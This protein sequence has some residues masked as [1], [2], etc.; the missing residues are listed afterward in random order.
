MTKK[1]YD[2]M[3]QQRAAMVA[4]RNQKQVLETL[5][6]DDP[7]KIRMVKYI[8]RYRLPFFDEHGP[9]DLPWLA[10]MQSIML[11]I[12][13]KPVFL[14]F[15]EGEHFEAT[16]PRLNEMRRLA[17]RSRGLFAPLEAAFWSH[18]VILAMSRNLQKEMMAGS[19]DS[20][21]MWKATI[22]TGSAQLCSDI[23]SRDAA[24]VSLNTHANSDGADKRVLRKLIDVSGHFSTA[25]GDAEQAPGTDGVKCLDWRS[26]ADFIYPDEVYRMPQKT[27]TKETRIESLRLQRQLRDQ[28]NAVWPREGQPLLTDTHK[29]AEERFKV[30]QMLSTIVPREVQEHKER[31]V[32]QFAA[33]PAI[34]H[35]PV[36][37]YS[38]RQRRPPP[39]SI[40]S[41]SEADSQLDN[42]PAAAASPSSETA[43]IAVRQPKTLEDIEFLVKKMQPLQT[44]LAIDT[45]EHGSFSHRSPVGWKSGFRTAPMSQEEIAGARAVEKCCARQRQ[46]LR[47]EIII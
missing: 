35:A 45:D 33:L 2:R 4:A 13:G 3:A 29:K 20:P 26:R 30:Q 31:L 10:P 9:A 37:S 18:P 23:S 39:S 16:L 24:G 32:P 11:H 5:A 38:A 44:L 15:A 34:A 36:Q 19:V 42:L 7:N 6:E 1:E 46:F 25:C 27:Q 40:R 21:T 8:K 12:H 41:S 43:T 47:R 28:K 14:T 22:I 17:A